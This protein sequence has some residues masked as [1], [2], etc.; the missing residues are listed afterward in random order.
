[1][2]NSEPD[3]LARHERRLRAFTRQ[4]ARL[5]R[6]LDDLHAQ[7]A[8]LS[9]WRLLSFAMLLFGGG[10][11]L[12]AW[13]LMPW[14]VVSALLLILFIYWVWRSHQVEASIARLSIWRRLKEDQIARMTL[15]WPLIP[16]AEAL[17]D[18]LDHPFGRDLDLVGERSLQRIIDLSITSEGSALLR[19]WLLEFEPQMSVLPE[20]QSRVRELMRMPS[21]IS[22]LTLNALLAAGEE[23]SA[24]RARWSSAQLLNWLEMETDAASLRP[25]LI[26]TLLLVPLNFGLLFAYLQ[27]W[28]PP[29]FLISWFIY[30]AITASQLRHVGPLFRDAASIIDTLRQLQAVFSSLEARSF[31]RSPA[32]RALTQPLR[33]A[34]QSP[35]DLLARA[36]RLLA[37]AGLRYNPF[38]ALFLNAI[39]PLDI[40]VAWR[41]DA[42]KQELSTLAPGWLAIWHELEALGSLANMGTLYPPATFADLNLEPDPQQ[43]P[44]AGTTLG[45]PLIQAADRV[46]NDFEMDSVGSLVMITG[47]N[48]AGKSTFL[49]TLGINARLALCGAPILAGSLVISPLRVFASITVTDSVTDGFS[50]FYAEVRRLKRLLDCLQEPQGVPVFFLID[51]IFRGTNN[52]ER[53]IGSRSFVDAL[54]AENGC[55]AI[56]T[57][58]L[59][60]VTLAQNNPQVS[61]YHFRDDVIDGRMVFDYKLHPGPCPTTNALRIMRLAGLPVEQ[62]AGDPG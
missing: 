8:R 37:A 36:N 50:F 30:G 15:A 31:S 39:F 22:R 60:L 3:R 52:R 47:S 24:V 1:M 33:D 45:H 51:E 46:Y 2:K 23:T 48:M 11:V 58:D 44:Y 7:Y 26:L 38:A 41:L 5:G 25:A 54:I 42:L 6:C 14:L 10:A 59:E 13:G 29:L 28:M 4:V 40:L 27:G 12:L 9:R 34:D 16:A 53:L 62:S 61:N 18:R 35:A 20:R 55:G 21:L 56:A 17:D 49:R 43:R 57:H 32:L 19:S